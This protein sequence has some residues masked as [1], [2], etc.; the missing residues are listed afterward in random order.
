MG[1]DR[2]SPPYPPKNGDTWGYPQGMNGD[3]W[4]RMAPPGGTQP[5][6]V[7]AA[8]S[9]LNCLL[10]TNQEHTAFPHASSSYLR[11][12]RHQP[13]RGRG[14]GQEE[15]DLPGRRNKPIRLKIGSVWSTWGH[16]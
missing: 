11:S 12:P 15:F 1:P 9:P 13:F 16:V 4:G 10:M 5:P 14:W 7:Y 3:E 8:S 6:S 2:M